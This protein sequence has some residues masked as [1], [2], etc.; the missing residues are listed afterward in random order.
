MRGGDE[1]CWLLGDGAGGVLLIGFCETDVE[2][3]NTD[4]IGADWTCDCAAPPG[5]MG[6][7]CQQI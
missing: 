3:S 4:G 1:V 7:V 6:E 2:A 5:P